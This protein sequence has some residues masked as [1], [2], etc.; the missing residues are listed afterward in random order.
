MAPRRRRP[1]PRGRRG[2][3]PNKVPYAVRA[4][5]Y[6]RMAEL[7][8]PRYLWEKPSS[9]G[10]GLDAAYE[11]FLADIVAEFPCFGSV[12]SLKLNIAFTGQPKRPSGVHWFDGRRQTALV[13]LV[14]GLEGG[15]LFD[16][17][18]PGLMAFPYDGQG[19]GSRRWKRRQQLARRRAA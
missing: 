8:G 1:R 15:F 10:R 11:Q 16:A 5:V 19:R 3:N 13:N 7:I 6:R 17:D 12:K 9:P 4:F 14:A 2:G 18:L